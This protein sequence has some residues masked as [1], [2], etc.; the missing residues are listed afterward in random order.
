VV[1]PGVLEEEEDPRSKQLTCS[2]DVDG[3]GNSW[4]ADG[5]PAWTSRAGRAGRRQR[6]R[7]LGDTG[8]VPKGCRRDHRA[9]WR[10]QNWKQ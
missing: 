9:G 5:T 1:E 10:I 2:H 4:W 6:E 8:M 3:E 7:V